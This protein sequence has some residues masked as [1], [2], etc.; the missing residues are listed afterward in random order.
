MVEAKDSLRAAA[1][2]VVRRLQ[3]S[4]HRA[5][6]A[7]GCVRDM[8]MSREPADYDIATDATPEQVVALFPGTV[9]V[10]KA[11]GVA[12]VCLGA[13]TCEVA[14]FRRDHGYTD[15][16]HPDSV[17]FSDPETDA[18]RRDFTINALFFDP[19]TEQVLDYV[20]GRRD[21]AA[22]LVRAVGDPF[23][24]FAEDH[25]RML[26]AVRFAGTLG[27]ELEPGTADSIRANAAKLAA[28]SEER[29]RQ[30]LTRILVESR[31][32][33]DALRTMDRLGLVEVVLPEV[34]AMKDQAQPPRFHPEGDVFTHTVLMLN[35]MAT[36]DHRLAWAVL[37]HD[38]GKP[39]TA[40]VDEADRIRFNRHAR[41]GEEMARQILTRLRFSAADTD[42]IAGC[43]GNHM[44]FMDVQ[45]MRKAT[46]R[47]LLGAPTFALEL[48]LHRLDCEAS[49]GKLDNYA[50][51]VEA[52]RA[53]E[54]EPVMPDPWVSGRDVM[55]LGVPHGPAVGDWKRRAYDMQLEG[56]VGGRDELLAWLRRELG[57][58][59]G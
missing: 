42:T 26:R 57:K 32:A 27:F 31:R 46:L 15:G 28:I 38:I 8:L 23:A 39:P 48:E 20:G 16:R 17:T 6:W 3:Q 21:L 13:S 19:V 50:F 56:A 35:K 11:F 2:A 45:R 33:G 24:R 47:K 29:V 22:R 12:R 4:G 36:T 5:Y 43:V 51:L 37:L 25:L 10:G 30:E 40:Q 9:V 1:T 55:A 41:K 49:H 14:T 7:G 52:L 59:G 18:N 44:R 54:Q 53:F 34:A 58:A